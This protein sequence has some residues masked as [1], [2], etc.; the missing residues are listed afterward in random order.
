MSASGPN[1]FVDLLNGWIQLYLTADGW[2][3]SRVHERRICWIP[4]EFREAKF[5]SGM[6]DGP[7]IILDFSGLDSYY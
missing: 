1:V 2:L 5:A 6:K 4:V 7:V 3:Y